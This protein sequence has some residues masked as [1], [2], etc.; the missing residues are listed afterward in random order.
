MIPASPVISGE[1]SDMRDV[2]LV[3][4]F[5]LGVVTIA[6]IGINRYDD[7]YVRC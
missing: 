6:G 3:I 2:M 4:F 1:Y 5:M 7:R